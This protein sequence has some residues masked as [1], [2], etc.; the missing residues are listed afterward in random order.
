VQAWLR[1]REGLPAI[2]AEAG[3]DSGR[4]LRNARLR[5][6]GWAPAF[7]DFRAGHARLADDA[8]GV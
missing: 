6:L 1:A 8:P 5:G 4:R 2:A 7:P 3:P